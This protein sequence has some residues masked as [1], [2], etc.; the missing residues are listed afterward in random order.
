MLGSTRRAR[1]SLGRR[2]EEFSLW[3]GP[4]SSID[5]HSR[6]YGPIDVHAGARNAP[7]AVVIGPA[8]LGPGAQV[9]RGSL[10]CQCV[11]GPG[12]RVS[13]GDCIV[14][15]VLVGQAPAKAAA[16]HKPS[17]PAS[18]QRSEPRLLRRRR[19]RAASRA[20]TGDKRWYPRLKRAIDFSAALVG[21]VVL[22]P[23]LGVTALL[24]K[25]SSRGPVLFGHEREGL[26][27]RVFRCWK[28]RT[29]I[30]RAHQQQR[31]LY[32]KNA[33]DGPQFK[34]PNDPRVTPLGKLLRATNID[35]LPQLYNVLLGHMSLI[36][37][38]PSPFRENQICIPWRKAR[39]SVRPGITGLWQVCRRERD[40][41][42]FH[43]WIYFDVLYVHMSL[44]L[45]LRAASHLSDYGWTL[46]RAAAAHDSGAE[47]DVPE[48]FDTL[49]WLDG[50]TRAGTRGRA[51]RMRSITELKQTGMAE[52]KRNR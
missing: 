15:R 40:A 22:A 21:L 44:W 41:G 20:P 34:L 23:L 42:D 49:R 31:A 11:F 19:R 32:V 36:G 48:A 13:A 18:A 6:L 14:R 12:A 26:N 47:A 30:D 29:M 10:V 16:G 50:S 24:V 7:H 4:G 27:G 2:S 17:A 5:P 51:A 38:R 9:A 39:L 25:L 35:E 8:V 33:V 45:D 28:F 43:Q 1:R 46:Q 52:G 37:P 3:A